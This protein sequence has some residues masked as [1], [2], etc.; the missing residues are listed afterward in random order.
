MYMYLSIQVNFDEVD[1][2]IAPVH[3]GAHWAVAVSVHLL[4]YKSYF[5]LFRHVSCRLLTLRHDTSH[6]WTHL[7]D[8]TPPVCRS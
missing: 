5:N 7:E 2:V 3:L 4:A 8:L 1:T 6:S